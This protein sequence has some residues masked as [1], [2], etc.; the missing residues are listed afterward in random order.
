LTPNIRGKSRMQQSC[1]CGSV[2]GRQVNW[3]PYR[4]RGFAP[5]IPSWT[6]AKPRR[7][8]AAQKVEAEIRDCTRAIASDGLS[9]FLQS[10]LLTRSSGEEE[11]CKPLLGPKATEES[12]RNVRRRCRVASSLFAVSFAIP[13][14]GTL[15]PRPSP[16][17]GLKVLRDTD[18]QV[19]EAPLIRE[20]RTRV[21]L[22]W[23]IAEPHNRLGQSATR[24]LYPCPGREN[25]RCTLSRQIQ[26]LS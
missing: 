10:R 16:A 14:S 13:A 20:S 21:K 9:S 5:L 24:L 7:R 3:R 18:I 1:T 4:D 15:N 25:H 6:R 26:C 2:R 8:P 23:I 22:E 17:S 11:Q 12:L 19:C